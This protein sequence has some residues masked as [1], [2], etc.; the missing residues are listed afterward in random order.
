M[1]RLEDSSRWLPKFAKREPNAGDAI[2]R[3]QTGFGVTSRNYAATYS[4]VV[5][6]ALTLV[7]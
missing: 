3:K 1:T 5:D 7:W 4:P 6:A 2:A